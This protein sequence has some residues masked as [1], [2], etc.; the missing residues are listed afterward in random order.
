MIHFRKHLL[1]A[2]LLLSALA[3]IIFTIIGR[4]KPIIS[5]PGKITIAYT[6]E[7]NSSLSQLS[8]A[9]NCFKVEGLGATIKLHDFEKS[10]SQADI[11]Q[12]LYDHV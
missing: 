10:A 6:I 3:F 9:K 8:F 7:F 4:Q 2:I 12:I 11:S 1:F 5:L